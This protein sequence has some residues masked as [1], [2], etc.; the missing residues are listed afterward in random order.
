MQTNQLSPAG[1]EQASPWALQMLDSSGQL[2]FLQEIINSD[3][4][5]AGLDE[6]DY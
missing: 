5:D 3:N 2:P 4:D 6:A 1:I